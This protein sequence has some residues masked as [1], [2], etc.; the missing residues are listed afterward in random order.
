MQLAS[1]HRRCALGRRS[2]LALTGACAAAP[3]AFFDSARSATT[4]PAQPTS[5]EALALLVAGN[6]RFAAGAPQHHLEL[7]ARRKATAGGQQPFALILSCA[8]SRV[9]PEFVFDQSI[10]TLFVVRVAGNYAATG[11][12]GSFEY[13]V[14]HFHS[15]L[16]VVLGHEGCGALKAT[17]DA[18]RTNQIIG[19]DLGEVVAALRSAVVAAKSEPGD[20]VENAI[21]ANIRRTVAELPR[22]ST[23]LSEA[24][25]TGKLSIRGAEYSQTSGLVSLL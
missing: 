11:G 24:A 25:K 7:E 2:F 12:V 10:G 13:A 1:N 3:L 22:M 17:L 9:A 8:D 6:K 19:G 18:V 15:P 5:E 23:L 20:P 21:R 16:L 4:A 14:E